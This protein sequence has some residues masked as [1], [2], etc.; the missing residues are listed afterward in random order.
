MPRRIPSLA[1]ALLPLRAASKPSL[2]GFGSGVLVAAL[3][4]E[5]PG[6]PPPGPPPP[7]AAVVASASAS[8]TTAAP[9]QRA[10]DP[11]K[12]GTRDSLCSRR[13]G[14][15]A[16]CRMTARR[17]GG[18]RRSAPTVPPGAALHYT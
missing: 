10:G 18:V 8:S 11:R 14:R 15:S 13:G 17:R 16:A 3:G 9:R 5:P 12:V 2:S 6:A 1:V 4:G 7:Q